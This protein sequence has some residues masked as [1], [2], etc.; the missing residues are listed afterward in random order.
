MI[1]SPSIPGF[2]TKNHHHPL[3]SPC[4]VQKFMCLRCNLAT[5]V[6]HKEI[7]ID[8]C[9]ALD[10][11]LYIYYH[12]YISNYIYIHTHIYSND[13][14]PK[15]NFN[16]LHLHICSRKAQA[17]FQ[18]LLSQSIWAHWPSKYLPTCR[19]NPKMHSPCKS[20]TTKR[21]VPWNWWL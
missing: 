13:F 3:S 6:Q 12:I 7:Y 1:G 19:E 20:K 10:I 5:I 16:W 11:Y 8:L 17:E 9:I 21:I 15:K 2:Q 14:S 4:F 18:Q